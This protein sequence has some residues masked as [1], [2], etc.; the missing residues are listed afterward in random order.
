MVD[1]GNT[2]I[3]VGTC[4]GVSDGVRILVTGADGF[5]GRTL[6]PQL[7]AVGHEVWRLV[8]YDAYTMPE[9]RTVY[10]D[11][12]DGDVDKAVRDAGPDI[13]VHLAG[14]SS[15][16]VALEQPVEA[17]LINAVGT[18][19]IVEAARRVHVAGF[20]LASTAGVYNDHGIVEAQNPYGASKIA[21][22]QAVRCS[23][24]PFVIMRPAAT[25]GRGL[26]NMPKFVI[27]ETIYQALT[28]ECIRLRDPNPTREFIFRDDHVDGYVRAIGALAAGRKDVANETFDL[29]SD[30]QIQIGTMAEMV[31][32][33]T[34]V[35]DIAFSGEY[36]DRE[37]NPQAASAKAR[38]LLGWSPRR[39]TDGLEQAIREWKVALEARNADRIAVA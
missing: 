15:A 23:K 17:V 26:V 5:I 20:V 31:G 37:Y 21:A 39:L 3:E 11:L 33:M 29:G 25:F 4:E 18:T 32:R 14:L 36:R 12:K 19:R 24:L 7:E 10:C 30:E 1:A 16:V 9:P 2:S 34:G 13:I 35:S 22:E 6:V 28:T 27:D 38:E 8:R